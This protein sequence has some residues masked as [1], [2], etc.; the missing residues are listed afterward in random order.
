[1]VRSEKLTGY[2]LSREHAHG[3]HKA[4]FFEALGFSIARWEV[5]AEALIAHAGTHG[6]K[7]SVA[8]AY[9]VRYVVEGKLAGPIGRASIVRA[10][11]FI[12]AGGSVPYFV[13][14]YPVKER[15]S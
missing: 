15:K 7:T 13:T 9:G 3:Q 2:L 10:I 8:T 12:E 14:A 6:V 5:L 1:M 11:W 4:R